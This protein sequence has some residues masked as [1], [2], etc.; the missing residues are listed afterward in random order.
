MS[1]IIPSHLMDLYTRYS[2]EWGRKSL[3]IP[4]IKVSYDADSK[5][6]FFIKEGEETKRIGPELKATI[7]KIRN[8]YFLYGDSKDDMLK[9]NEFDG[10]D[11]MLTL[12]KG[13]TTLI[14]G[15]YKEVK[16]YIK[17]YYPTTKYLSIIYVL[18][19]DKICRLY[20][21]PGSRQNLWDYQN[22]TSGTPPFAFITHFITSQE[23]HG[24]VTYYALQFKKGDT[25]PS[26]EVSKNIQTRLELDRALLQYDAAKQGG[27]E[28]QGAPEAP[29][30]ST[31]Q[32]H[33]DMLEEARAILG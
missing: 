12:T 18:Y 32:G 17:A 31:D 20:A 8:Q 4:E 21:K 26:E 14:S 28:S 24:T 22:L 19:E 2:A 5:G 27:Q 10:F 7:L 1:D 3:T 6:E 16:D 13:G 11:G 25:L 15:H 29:S 9:T 23:K 33:H 30:S